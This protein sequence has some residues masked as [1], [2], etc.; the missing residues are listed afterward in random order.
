M[1][2]SNKCCDTIPHLSAELTTAARLCY[3]AIVKMALNYG[4]P[5]KHAELAEAF[6]QAHGRVDQA[7]AAFDEH[8][9]SHR[10]HENNASAVPV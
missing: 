10:S 3:E 2:M 5:P 4:E 9:R 6:K 1:N 8:L 7:L